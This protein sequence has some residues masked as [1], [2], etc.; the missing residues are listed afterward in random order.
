MFK[1]KGKSKIRFKNQSRNTIFPS[2]K[3]NNSNQIKFLQIFPNS[4]GNPTNTSSADE[5]A[6]FQPAASCPGCL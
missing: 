1:F 2:S 4:E 5:A 3:K 6:D